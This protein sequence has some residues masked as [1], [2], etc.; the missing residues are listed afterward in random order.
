MF[1]IPGPQDKY[2]ETEFSVLKQYVENGGSILVMACEGG[3]KKL[4]TNIN[5]FLEEYGISVN[6]GELELRSS[7]S[8]VK[9]S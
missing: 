4:K 9:A 1:V 6:N 7:I 8:L 3:E 5:F 2:T